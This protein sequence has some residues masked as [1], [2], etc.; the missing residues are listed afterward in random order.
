MIPLTVFN[1][2]FDCRTSVDLRADT[3]SCTDSTKNN[4]LNVQLSSLHHLGLPAHITSHCVSRAFASSAPHTSCNCF[5][6]RKCWTEA[7]KHTHAH[8]CAQILSCSPTNTLC[9]VCAGMSSII[10]RRLVVDKVIQQRNRC[11]VPFFVFV[12]L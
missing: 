4:P 3:S 7:P 10:D 8:S 5:T 6:T 12:L 2:C 9:I 1:G 11:V